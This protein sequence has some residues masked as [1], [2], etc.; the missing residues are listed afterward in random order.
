[1]KILYR[2]RP[3]YKKSVD[4][5]CE[6]VGQDNNG[7]ERRWSVT[8][9]YRWGQ[10]FV[11]DLSE[12]P[13]KDDF[14]HTFDFSVG[15]GSELDDLCSIDFEFDESFTDEEREQ[16]EQNWDEGGRG[17]LDESSEW[18]AEYEDITIR[19]PFIV[20][21]IDEEVY[22]VSIEDVELQN[23][24]AFVATTAWPFSSEKA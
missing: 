16:I 23:R 18:T 1:M 15:W 2:V 24:P 11:E 4:S 5:F 17:W 7:N 10:G 14:E 19:G 3:E 22:N 6:V 8:E 9:T 12:L 21:K 13:Y 20:D